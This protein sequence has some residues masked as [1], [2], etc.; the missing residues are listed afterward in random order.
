MEYEPLKKRLNNLINRFPFCRKFLFF[1]FDA[2]IL[3]QWYVKRAISSSLSGKKDFTFFDAGA[4]FGQYSHYVLKSYPLAK[5][6][7]VDIEKDILCSFQESRDKFDKERIRCETT[8][9]TNYVPDEQQ[10]LIIAVDILEHIEDDLAVLRNFRQAAAPGGRLI[11]STP[12]AG[13]E[14]GF[15]EEH[16]R[17]GYT[18]DDLQRK[19]NTAGWE[20][21][22]LWYSYGFFGNIAWYLTIRIPLTL[23][24]F[25]P[26]MILFPAYYLLIYP[27]A[28]IMMNIDYRKDNRKGKGLVVIAKPARDT[29]KKEAG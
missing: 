11:V 19:L 8:D 17:N 13:K 28:L 24:K 3:R 1:L 29:K 27:L 7:A 16:F 6:L 5:V 20:I 26:V 23:F 12:F 18:R 14:A 25:R 22:K 21:E 2:L 15:T 10:Y 9:L 4:G